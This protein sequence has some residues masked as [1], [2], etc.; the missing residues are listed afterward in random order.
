[1][2]IFFYFFFLFVLFVLNRT[3]EEQFFDILWAIL[4][5]YRLVGSSLTTASWISKEKK[6]KEDILKN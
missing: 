4:T 6:N 1:M 2:I 3:S 5:F